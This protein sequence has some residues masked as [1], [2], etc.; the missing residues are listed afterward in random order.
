MKNIINQKIIDTHHHLWDPR[1]NKYDWLIS[2]GHEIFNNVYLIKD[3]LNDIGSL[4]IYKSVHVQ[5]EINET[6]TLYETEWIQSVSESGIGK[7]KLPNAI[8]GFVNF[9]DE[10]VE[11]TLERHTL[12]SN[13]RGI[14]QILN[15]DINDSSSSHAKIDYLK[16]NIWLKNFSLLKKYNLSFDLSILQNQTDDAAKLINKEENILFIINHTLSP[17]NITNKISQDWIANIK[18]LSS[19][20]N[21]AIKLSGFGEFNSNWTEDSIRPLILN[22]IDNFG[23]NRCMFGSNFPVDKYLCNASYFDYWNAYYNVV[24]DF[25]DNEKD[26]LFF[27]NAET[28]YKI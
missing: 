11:K 12:F 2:P 7:N 3:Y 4:N 19:F 26:N 5:A 23:I 28:F 21:V 25:T 13:F 20:D 16:E 14:R 22:S 9:L 18:L 15:Y 6:E 1:S 10:G 8:I 24:S 17:L 27:K